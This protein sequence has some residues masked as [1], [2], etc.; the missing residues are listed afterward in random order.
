MRPR[1][2]FNEMRTWKQVWMASGMWQSQ[3]GPQSRKN[4]TM[5]C[6]AMLDSAALYLLR[7]LW[8]FETHWPQTIKAFY[9]G[10]SLWDESCWIK[11]INQSGQVWLLFLRLDKL[12]HTNGKHLYYWYWSAL[13][14]HLF[15]FPVKYIHFILVVIKT[16]SELEYVKLKW[17]LFIKPNIS[18]WK[19]IHRDSLGSLLFLHMHSSAI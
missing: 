17:L 6:G 18:F 1:L 11:E 19:A 3:L 2:T 9:F 8:R 12:N 4:S 14:Y 5:Q 10:H 7:L 13:W 15:K 16:R